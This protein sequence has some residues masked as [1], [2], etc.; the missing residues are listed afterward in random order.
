VAA[1]FMTTQMYLRRAYKAN[2]NSLQEQ[3]DE[4]PK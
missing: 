1:V 4:K 2:I 3:L